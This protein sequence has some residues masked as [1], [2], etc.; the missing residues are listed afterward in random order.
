MPDE[1]FQQSLDVL[2]KNYAS[3]LKEKINALFSLQEKLLDSDYGYESIKE[4]YIAAHRISGS[5]GMYGFSLIS[6][7][8]GMLEEILYPAYKGTGNNPAVDKNEIYSLLCKLI[9]EIGKEL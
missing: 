7:K 8:A 3:G 9:R 6:E 2:K 4:L 1:N 5:S